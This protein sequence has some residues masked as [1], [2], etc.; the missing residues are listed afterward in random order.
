MTLNILIIG[1]G[2]REHTIA[3][4]LSQSPK[5]T[6]L[7]TAPGNAGMARL[8]STLDIKDT[9][10]EGLLKSA[11]D[12]KIDVTV[13]GPEAPLAAGVVDRFQSAGMAVFGPTKAAAEIEWSKVFSKDLMQRHGIPCARSAAFTD[14]KKSL[15]IY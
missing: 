7:Y 3:W 12:L 8:S 9:D 2:A 6:A 13:V 4:K 10:V 14:L 1:S 11:R 5:V 15:G